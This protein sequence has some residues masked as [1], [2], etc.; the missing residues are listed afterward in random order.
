MVY[1]FKKGAH[2][3]A[4]VS[5]EQV[6]ADKDLAIQ[7][8]G[9]GSTKAITDAVEENPDDFPAL[10]KFITWDT[11]LAGRERHEDQIGRALASIV[12]VNVTPSQTEP[13][14]ALVITVSDR[15]RR[16]WRPVQWVLK[17]P[18]RRSDLFAELVADAQELTDKLREFQELDAAIAKDKRAR[19]AA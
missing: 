3:P 17:R 4:G 15:G 19:K 1:Q 2:V 5:A 11:G 12:V 6:I 18:D 8:T 10:T 9:N 7:R 14:R 16:E 13:V